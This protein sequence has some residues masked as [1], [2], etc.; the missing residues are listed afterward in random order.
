VAEELP[1]LRG[2]AATELTEFA[3]EILEGRNWWTISTVGRDGAPQ[4]TIVWADLKHGHIHV[5][6]V[7]G[8]AKARNIERDP[9]VAL[10]WV[11]PEDPMNFVSISGRVVDVLEGAAGHADMAAL[12]K[13][14]T[15]RDEYRLWNQQRI[16]YVIRATY[17][18]ERTGEA[19]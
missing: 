8:R 10:T 18:W 9:R 15:G 19:E 14:Y 5:N 7:V 16:G 1:R 11:S 13:K 17:V 6:S 4:A 12:I 3:R 2:R